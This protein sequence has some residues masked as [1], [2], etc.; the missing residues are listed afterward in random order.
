M[1]DRG[2][3]SQGGF[4][5]NKESLSLSWL[6]NHC[7]AHAAGLSRIISAIC[8]FL[9]MTY[10]ITPLLY[11]AFFL[12]KVTLQAKRQAVLPIALA[13]AVE[14]LLQDLKISSYVTHNL[15]WLHSYSNIFYCKMYAIC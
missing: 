4:A 14:G 2:P 15:R 13:F 6:E 3:R 8:P 12:S 7:K 10:L 5:I 9:L 11:G 1:S